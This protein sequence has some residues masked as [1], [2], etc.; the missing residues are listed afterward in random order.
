VPLVAAPGAFG[1]AFRTPKVGVAD[2]KTISDRAAQRA[3]RE[4]D[5]Q[6]LYRLRPI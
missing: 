5:R 4:R 1:V 6:D 2:R 3:A